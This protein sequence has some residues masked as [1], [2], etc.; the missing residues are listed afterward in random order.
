MV[1]D[2]W[3]RRAARLVFIKNFFVVNKKPIGMVKTKGAGLRAQPACSM[4]SQLV[5]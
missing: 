5:I 2:K 3:C 1:V 4:N